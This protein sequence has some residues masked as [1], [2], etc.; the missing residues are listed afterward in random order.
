M[1][2][3]NRIIHR[4]FVYEGLFNYREFFRKIDF[5]LRD[6]FYDKKERGTGEYRLPDGQKYI[7]LYFE[8]WKKVTDY[9]KITIRID[10]QVKE[11]KEVEIEVDGKKQKLNQGRIECALTGYLTLDYD[12]RMEKTAMIQFMRD[13]FHRYVYHY[14]TKKY[15]EMVVDDL[16][17]LENTLRSYLNTFQRKQVQSYETGREHTRFA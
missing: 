9:Y 3:K 14:I 12:D 16:G 5:W 2:E 11:M 10:L 6:K 15:M 7:S 13:L 1:V 8:P 17:D 4:E